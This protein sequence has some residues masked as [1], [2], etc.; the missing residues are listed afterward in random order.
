M[1]SQ[2]TRGQYATPKRRAFFLPLFAP[3][4]FH[5]RVKLRGGT[6][7]SKLLVL[8]Q[9]LAIME[10][11]FQRPAQVG[12]GFLHLAR[13]GIGFGKVVVDGDQLAAGAGLFYNL[14]LLGI[15][16]IGVELKRLV[17]GLH[18]GLVLLVGEIRRTQ[19]AVGD[20]RVGLIF[21]RQLVGAFRLL[22]VVLAVV[23]G[24]QIV[25]RVGIVAD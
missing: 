5:E 12:E 20:G 22:V 8:H 23:N 3:V 6:Q 18:P 11:G 15:E 10:S 13:G 1:G 14:A 21:E 17:V 9:L 2:D 16:D 25:K 7:R 4:L 24:G 19:I